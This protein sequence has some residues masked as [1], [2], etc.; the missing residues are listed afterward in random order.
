MKIILIYPKPDDFKHSRFGYSLNLLYLASILRKEGYQV[1]YIDYSVDK[2][3]D[4][5]LKC[6]LNYARAVIIELDS[7]PLKRSQNFEHGKSIIQNI[8]QIDKTI[9]IIA[10]G[11][12][13]IVNNSAI[14]GCD[15]TYTWEPE[16]TIADVLNKLIFNT[17]LNREKILNREL[18]NLDWLPFPARDLVSDSIT[19]GGDSYPPLAKSALIQTSRGCLNSC[20]FCQR[21]SWSKNYRFHSIDYTISEFKEL[22]NNNI[23][24]VWI[25]DDNF[26]F[27]LQ[28]AKELLKALIDKETTNNMKIALSSWTKI[29]H[30]FIDLAKLAGVSIISFG[31]ESRNPEI[32]SFYG[33]DIDFKQAEDIIKY[34]DEKGIY[35]VG[36]FIIG[37]PM[38]TDQT[39][40]ETF[41][42]ALS[43]NIDEVN[44]KILTYMP[45]AELF[46]HLSP[47][48]KKCEKGLF[49]CIENKLNN[50]PLISLRER[51]NTF[52]KKFKNTKKH[53][54]Q[55]K[56]MKFGLPYIINKRD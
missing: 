17:P 5:K 28:R 21:K 50:F 41:N 42:Y 1:E 13:C 12:Y 29:D 48:I 18:I 4:F 43:L 23:V 45:G 47:E 2:N 49:A 53:N 20:R 24:N 6:S 8:R 39:I 27:N 38:E 34:A 16:L 32:L 15:F 26:T 52:I 7:Y 10:F 35:I 31:L 36:N 55:K 14:S 9:P 56:I 44:V 40:E 37:A 30:E 19:K 22:K 25:T 54:L 46:D 11:Y 51:I 3:A 33:K